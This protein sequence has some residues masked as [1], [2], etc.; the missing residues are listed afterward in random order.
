MKELHNARPKFYTMNSLLT[1]VSCPDLPDCNSACQFRP[2]LHGSYARRNSLIWQ[3]EYCLDLSQHEESDDLFCFLLT[4]WLLDK[5]QILEHWLV[6][7]ARGAS[8]YHK[9]HF[10]I[11]HSG[12]FTSFIWN[13]G[14]LNNMMNYHVPWQVFIVTHRIYQFYLK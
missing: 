3:V 11:S 10:V 5:S 7:Q 9:F 1:T 8:H 6:R 2:Q 12:R 13:N 4:A 14:E